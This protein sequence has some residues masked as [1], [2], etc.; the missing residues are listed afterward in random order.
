MFAFSSTWNVWVLASNWSMMRPSEI[1]NLHWTTPW[2]H[3]AQVL[4][5]TDKNFLCSLGFLGMR[6]Q[7]QLLNVCHQKGFALHASHDH[8][9]LHAI[10]FNSQFS[11]M[12]DPDG[13][14]FL[15]YTEDIGLKTNKGGLRYH[16]FM[17]KTA[18][19]CGQ[20]QWKM[21]PIAI[22]KYI[23]LLPRPGPALHSIYS[24]ERN[25]FGKVWF[26]NW[27]AVVECLHNLSRRSA[28]ML[29]FYTNHSL[30][31]TSATKLYQTTLM[32]S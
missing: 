4:L 10:P 12:R 8:W 16:C 6:F 26:I 31:S 2:R 5:A 24:Q 19:L 29:V 30:R 11:F 3:A 17:P 14:I 20:K 22:L 7:D 27:P 23:S 13:K 1:L 15:R 28:M 9:A 18:P 32:N 25:F 21:P